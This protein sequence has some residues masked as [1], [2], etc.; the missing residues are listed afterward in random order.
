MWVGDKVLIYVCTALCASNWFVR[1]E[2]RT[3]VRAH[4]EGN[5]SQGRIRVLRIYSKEEGSGGGASPMQPSPPLAHYS[6]LLLSLAVVFGAEI[7]L[8]FFC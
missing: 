6:E 5:L 1:E 7:K 3:Q 2:G 4:N 8:C